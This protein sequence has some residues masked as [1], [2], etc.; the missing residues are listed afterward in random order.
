GGT[1]YTAQKAKYESS[2]R[3]S[4]SSQFDESSRIHE[5]EPDFFGIDS[6]KIKLLNMVLRVN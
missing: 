1:S 2:S 3:S 4:S 6:S 5:S